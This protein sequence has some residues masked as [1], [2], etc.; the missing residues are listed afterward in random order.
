MFGPNGAWIMPVDDVNNV[1]I[2]LRTGLTKK[3]IGL[4]TVAGIR[5][6]EWQDL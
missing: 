2:S 3:P 6:V 5:T 1:W 4:C